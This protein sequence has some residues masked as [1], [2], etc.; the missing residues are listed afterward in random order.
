M[1]QRPPELFFSSLRTTLKDRLKQLISV[2]SELERLNIAFEETGQN[3]V[4]VCCP[5]PDH[6]DK[7]PSCSVNTDTKI[8]HCHGCRRGGDFITFM[9]T[10]LGIDRTSV[11][12]DLRTRYEGAAGVAPI[13]PRTLESA[14]Q[15]L[16][17]SPLLLQELYK[18]GISDE[19]IRKFRLGKEKSRIT[20]PIPNRDGEIVNIRKYLPG[21]PGKDKFRNAKGRGKPNRLY[22]IEQLDYNRIV[23]CGG[24]IKAL[25]VSQRLNSFGFG[26]ITQTSGEGAWEDSFSKLFSDKEVFV[27]YDIDEPGQEAAKSLCLLLYPY[28]ASVKNI[29]LPIDREEI[30]HGDV[31]DFFGVL[32]K[33]SHDLMSLL[34]TTEEWRPSLVDHR[35]NGECIDTSSLSEALKPHYVSKQLSLTATVSILDTTPYAIP[36]K[37]EPIC[38]RDQKLCSMCPV[39]HS[40][41]KLNDDGSFSNPEIELN[42]DGIHI[43]KM[44]AAS[45]AAQRDAIME[46]LKIPSCKTVAFNPTEYLKVVDGRLSPQLSISTRES[47]DL[48]IPALIVDAEVD[49][50]ET[51]QFKGRPYPHPRNQQA[52]IVA[53]EAVP[54]RDALSSFEIDEGRYDSL[55]IFQPEQWTKE[56]LQDKLDDIY[57]DLS[58]NVTR[59]FKR[60]DLHLIADLSY[61]SP[62]LVTFDARVVKGWVEVLIV[63]DSSQGK[64]ETV[65]NLIRHYDIGEKF[66]CKGAS[67]A[68]LLGGC[69]QE[70][71]RWFV[72]WGVI[73]T[74]DRRLVF[75][76]ELKGASTEVIGRLTDMRS[77][78]IAQLTKII[79][80]KTHA[81]TR[82]IACSN[83]RSSLPIRSYSFGIEAVRELIGN[84]EDLRRFD[85]VLVVSSEQLSSE[86]INM[87]S[88]NRPVVEHVYT[89]DLCKTLILWSWTREAAQ[90]IIPKE[91]EKLILKETNKLCGMFSE[92]I[93]IVDRGSMRYKLARLAASLAARTFSCTSNCESILVRDCHVEVIVDF[94]KKSYL[95]PIN[96]YGDYSD[97]VKAR[98]TIRDP[99]EIRKRIASLTYPVEIIESFLSKER[100]GVIDIR[101]WCGG[102]MDE[103]VQL[104]SFLVRKQAL[105]REGREYR[106]N[107]EFIS[108]LK[109]LKNDDLIKEMANDNGQEEF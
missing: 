40:A 89:S 77:S 106:K 97:A 68:G 16:L 25:G 75:L 108:L 52:V 15:E 107:S 47:D 11:V 42:T 100:I 50:N 34:E 103:A 64:T 33:T 38:S 3:E 90:V 36:K 81:R 91:V 88:E 65:E 21:A 76:E 49:L 27:C 18:R 56:S 41:K 43:A 74:H 9:A 19:T 48:T 44:V 6:D 67:E 59:I 14:Y 71:N 23:V 83:P 10:V 78:G 32:K 62:L 94:I 7:S 72:S 98:S 87:L 84:P 12:L 73:P 13:N 35:L 45:D 54:V 69:R 60:N 26:A 8:F 53:K 105:V 37:V 17:K 4:R 57:S 101:D 55:R 93:P 86:H 85:V 104:L 1:T 80:K 39:Y 31:N 82:L 5:F 96:G 102:T 30:P 2:L 58:A 92:T 95:D 99:E 24:E 66:E 79:R 22:P 51:Y 61:H 28:A 46:D 29:V 63:G 109:T 70:G 20:I